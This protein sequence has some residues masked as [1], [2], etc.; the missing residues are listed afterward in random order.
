MNDPLA[1][2]VKPTHSR[3]SPSGAHRWMHCLGSPN[4]IAKLGPLARQSGRAADEGT[5]AHTVYADCLINNQDAWEYAGQTIEVKN[6][7]GTVR[8]EFIV[9]AEMQEAVQ[10]GIDYIRKKLEKYKDRNPILMVEQRVSSPEDEDAYGTADTIIIIPGDRIIVPDFKYGKNVSVEPHEEQLLSYGHYA[11]ETYAQYFTDEKTI[12]E[13]VIIQPRLA[14]PH[15]LGQIRKHI[16][17]KA[18][19]ARW[20]YGDALP[21]LVGSRDPEA[22]LTIGDWC[23]FCPANQHCPALIGEVDTLPTGIQPVTM[24]DDDLNLLMTK[25]KPILQ[26]FERAEEELFTRAM[27]GSKFPDWKL[28]R[29]IASRIWKDGAEAAITEKYGPAAY[30]EPK[31]KSPP[32]ID[33]MDGGKDVTAEWSQ[34]PQTGLTIAPRGDKRQEAS[35]DMLGST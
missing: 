25:K 3:R 12:C 7:D 13:L 19:L 31:L 11:F 24:T 29:K 4:L 26:L 20:F 2:K 16:T 34:K 22:V 9:D 1:E 23:R 21:A 5:A 33:K 8:A 17:N 28:V 6:D 30:T 27:H 18:E 35:P 32:D 14:S 10:I 15:P